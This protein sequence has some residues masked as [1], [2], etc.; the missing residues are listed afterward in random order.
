[1]KILSFVI[2]AYNAEPFLDKVIRSMLVPE[3]LDVLEIIIVNDGS[4]DQT[5]TIAQEY[6]RK[7]PE[8][9]RLISQTNKGHGGAL[10]TGCAAAQGKFLKVIDADDWVET[11]NLPVFLHFLEKTDSDVVLT[12]FRTIDISNGEV[13]KWKSY[14]AEF[15]RE[16][17]MEEI[18]AEW[19]GFYR[20]LTFH[21]ITYNTG[22]YREYGI[23]LSEHVFYED[24]EFAT[25]PCCRAR[26][27]TPLDI[28][29][30]N[31]RI[32]DVNQ[33]VS[34]ASKLKRI[35]HL[36]TVLNRMI[37]ECRGA[38]NLTPAG[39]KYAIIKTQEL[40]LSYFTTVLLIEPNKSFGRQEARKMMEHFQYEL[41]EV[42]AQANKKYRVFCMMNRLHISKATWDA[43]VNSSLYNRLR[44]NHSFD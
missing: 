20:C 28:C 41:P 30:Y 42:A 5:A 35:G 21:G 1:M 44:K 39:K 4:V 37:Q 11:Q 31:Y 13:R 38:S 32:G 18:M 12:H 2:P 19:R 33:S 14:P 3:L 26:T 40:L 16:L 17:S 36:E 43:I 6:C 25:F 9:V 22:F 23:W 7:Y 15:G 27:I 29:I 34:A 8:T 10:N 24:Y